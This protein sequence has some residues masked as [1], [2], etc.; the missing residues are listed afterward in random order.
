MVGSRS[1]RKELGF[2]M[3]GRSALVGQ[4]TYLDLS[5]GMGC[6]TVSD[7][8]GFSESQPCL[9]PRM[10]QVI[11]PGD[12]L[13]VGSLLSPRP[14]L[15]ALND[16][17]AQECGASTPST[18][19]SKK[20]KATESGCGCPGSPIVFHPPTLLAPSGVASTLVGAGKQAGLKIHGYRVVAELRLGR[21]PH[22]LS[23]KHHPSLKVGELTSVKWKVITEVL[24]RMPPRLRAGEKRKVAM[25]CS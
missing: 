17:M 18:G 8:L 11:Q 25:T 13:T 22:F 7:C 1:R 20:V 14:P 6:V 10:G 19:C 16:F 5:P 4:A 9:S 23:P 15:P 12:T 21:G 24:G 3:A 2:Y